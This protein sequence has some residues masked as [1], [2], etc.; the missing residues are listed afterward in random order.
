[1]KDYRFKHSNEQEIVLE[2][3]AVR[4]GASYLP[5][6]HGRG[7]E[8]LHRMDCAR[9]GCSKPAHCRSCGLCLGHCVCQ[10]GEGA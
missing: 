1:M 5:I 7:L 2:T 9:Q 6:H 3:V 8:G 10:S 4:D